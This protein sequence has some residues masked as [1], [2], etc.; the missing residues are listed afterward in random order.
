MKLTQEVCKESL[1]RVRASPY[2]VFMATE[3]TQRQVA[4]ID[5]LRLLAHPLRY[6]IAQVLRK[7]PA[8]STS[9][10]RVMGLN[11]GATSYHLRQLSA[12]G[13]IEE[14]P[15]DELS[16]RSHGRERWWR[17]RR[18]DLRF[19]RRS[20]QSPEMRAAMDE[21]NR[22]EFATDLEEFARFQL[23]REELGDWGDALPYSRGS[24]RVT[25]E[26]LLEFF[27]EYIALLNRYRRSDED[28]P[29]GARAVLTRFIAFPAIEPTPSSEEG[30]GPME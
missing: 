26:E 9:L 21:L 16:V 3:R 14:V 5:T 15:E 25:L 10:A 23:Y 28:T 18:V 2:H 4:D 27:E 29:P 13:L 17:A 30:G 8:T 22:L 7:G 20:E 19:P 12:H 1:Q 6:R 11:T 24:I